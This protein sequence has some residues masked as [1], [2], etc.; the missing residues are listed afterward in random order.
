V[1]NEIDYEGE[2]AYVIGSPCRDISADEALEQV[3]EYTVLNDV[4]ARDLQ[5]SF[6]YENEDMSTGS[7]GRQCN[8]Q[9]R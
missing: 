6:S 9:R 7:Q 5:L 2:L 1:T 8:Q 4:S 3:A